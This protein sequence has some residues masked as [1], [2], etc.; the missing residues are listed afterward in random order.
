[1]TTHSL[2]N[3]EKGSG[4]G[5]PFPGTGNVSLLPKH[6]PLHGTLPQNTE[7]TNNTSGISCCLSGCC[8]YVK[9]H[10]KVNSILIKLSETKLCSDTDLSSHKRIDGNETWCR[11]RTKYYQQRLK[12][13]DATHEEVLQ[14]MKKKDLEM[15]LSTI[16]HSNDPTQKEV[17]YNIIL[18]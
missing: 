6:C 4:K 10:S 2:K 1:M 7:N 8:C 9:R 13:S 11:K 15:L 14:K 3:Y 12:V 16:K 5:D 18:D 17:I